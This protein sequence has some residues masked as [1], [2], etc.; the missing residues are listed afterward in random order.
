MIN[1]VETHSGIPMRVIAGGV[2]TIP[3]ARPSTSRC[4]PPA[5]L[6]LSAM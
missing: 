4:S 3:E 5:T 6:G 1:A 2:P